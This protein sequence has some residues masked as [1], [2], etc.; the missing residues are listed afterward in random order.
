MNYDYQGRYLTEVNLRYDGS[1]RFRRGSRWQWS[2]SFSLGWNIAQEKFF[3]PLNSVVDQLKLR[4]S[5]GELGNQ[6]TTNYYPTYRKMKLEAGKGD[7]IQGGVRP[8]TAEVEE[9]IS[10][11]LT[12]ESV[13]SYDIGLDFA[14]FNNRLSG[15]FDYFKR[16]TKG[17][18]G[19]APQLP[20][21]LGLNPP[22]TNNCD[23]QTRGWEVSLTWRDRLNNGLGYGITATLSDQTTY[24]DS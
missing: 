1:S 7:W 3:E 5:Y 20:V 22:K 17:M 15:S 13:R 21:T 9:L 12:W 18:V 11:T 24:I 16:Y 19:P 8:N 23:L 4:F 6:N 2:P 10:S 14:L